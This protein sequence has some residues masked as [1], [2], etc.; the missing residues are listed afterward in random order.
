[1]E[2]LQVAI[3][4][5]RAQREG[6]DEAEGQAS[7]TAKPAGQKARK[8][9]A[10]SQT[11]PS[12]HSDPTA[13]WQALQ[14]IDPTGLLRASES[15]ITTLKSGPESAPFDILR[16]RILHQAQTNGWKR[17]A[18]TSPHSGCGK[19]LTMVNL[20]FSFARQAEQRTLMLDFDLRRPALAKVL[21]QTPAHTM[22]D[23]L[24][25]RVP[26][27]RHA[28]RHGD[29]LAFGLNAGPVK[30][31]SELLQSTATRDTLGQ[32]EA[33]Y[34]PDLVLFDMPPL[35]STDDSIGFLRFVDAAIIIV[36]AEETPMNQIDVA[37]RQVA[38]LT[39][40]MGIVLN[41]C[42]IMDGE[43]GYENYAS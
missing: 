1:M 4:K 20:G 42:R 16:T 19:T 14:P 37:E 41:K 40:V 32:I 11:T 29:N 27:A 23:V 33:D 18:I 13:L 17:I 28:L 3:E 35:R 30:H 22:G 43:Y 7:A 12:A 34:Q 2:R 24:Q 39:N 9:P 10:S 38:E 6:T 31:S 15:R 8:A 26:F 21:W 5:A 25:G 36:A